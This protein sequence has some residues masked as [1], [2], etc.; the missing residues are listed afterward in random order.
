MPGEISITDDT[1]AD[2]TTHIAEGQEELNSLLVKVKESGK[3]G[4]KLNIKKTKIITSGPIT[5]W[6]IDGKTM[7]SVADFIL[8]GSKINADGD[9]S[10]KI[11]RY[12]LFGRKAMTN[13]DSALKSRDF[14]LPT[15]VCIVKLCFFQ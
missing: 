7:E 11:K 9:C 10:H 4:L 8:W 3:P 1:H 2:D 14:S 12:L 13:L 15:K 5:S 6:Q